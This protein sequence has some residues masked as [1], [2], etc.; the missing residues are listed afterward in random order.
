METTEEDREKYHRY[1]KVRASYYYFN[2]NENLHGKVADQC[3]R[4][5]RAFFNL[6]WLGEQR[7]ER[8]EKEKQK[9]AI[10]QTIDDSSSETEYETNSENIDIG[11]DIF[12]P[13]QY[14]NASEPRE[15]IETFD[16]LV[17]GLF[18]PKDTSTQN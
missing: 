8:M 14:D 15:T 2:R 11:D 13:V 1:L 4:R 16:S 7:Q 3:D 10:V 17:N 12:T 9:K 5:R 6:I 18:V